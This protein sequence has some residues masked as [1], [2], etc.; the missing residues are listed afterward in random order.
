MADKSVPEVPY[1]VDVDAAQKMSLDDLFHALA[2]SSSGLSS[3]E[4]EQRREKCGPNA[5]EEQ[6]RSPFREIFKFFWGPI[7]WMIEAAALL[8][9]IADDFNDFY[10][11]MFMLVFNALIGF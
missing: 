9:L 1:A 4:A 3:A 5:L 7:P 10:I 2:A 8:S 11:I 6:K